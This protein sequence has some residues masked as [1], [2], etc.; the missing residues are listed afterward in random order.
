MAPTLQTLVAKLTCKHCLGNGSTRWQY[1]TRAPGTGTLVKD[2][3]TVDC[4]VC[5]GSGIDPAWDGDEF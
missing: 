3:M 5:E 4:R 2:G 1:N